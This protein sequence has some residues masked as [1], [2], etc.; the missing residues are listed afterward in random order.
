VFKESEII[1]FKVNNPS[2]N[3]T[4]IAYFDRSNSYNSSYNYLDNESYLWTDIHHIV[5][6]TN[7]SHKE[8]KYPYESQFITIFYRKITHNKK[9]YEKDNSHRVWDW[10]SFELV[11]FRII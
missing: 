1:G 10:F 6:E 11:F 7:S 9:C 3:V 8:S 2:K 5:H 4:D